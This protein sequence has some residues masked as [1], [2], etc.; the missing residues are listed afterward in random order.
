MIVTTRTT[1]DSPEA[2]R[3]AWWHDM[4]MATLIPTA[5]HTDHAADFRASLTMLDFGLAQISSMFYP[6]ISS[7]RRTPELI[8]RSDPEYLQLSLTVTGRMRLAQSKNEAELD[9]GGLVLY[10]SSYPFDGSAL[11]RHGDVVRQIVVQLPRRLLPVP[12]DRLTPLLSTRMP[13]DRGFGEVLRR[14]LIQVTERPHEYGPADGPRLTTVLV[15]LIAA[16]IGQR[17]DE[18]PMPPADR[19]PQALYLSVQNFILRN[20]SDPALAPETIASAHH[21]SAR[22]LH[23][24]FQRHGATVAGLVRRERLERARRDLADPLL[25]DVTVSAIAHRLGFRRP[26]DFG[27]AFRAAYGVPP[28]DYRE[29]A[30]RDTGQQCTRAQRLSRACPSGR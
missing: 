17:V 13:T 24:L 15:D 20:L 2:D 29:A 8:R 27:R 1:E 23:R 11:S 3:F 28:R 25:A 26:A 6:S 16:A 21:L 7:V 10:D 5:I 12:P 18:R 30:L 19:H 14:F 4:T 9:D 22:S